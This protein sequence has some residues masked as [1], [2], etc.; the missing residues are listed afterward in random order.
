MR[1]WTWLYFTCQV[2]SLL[3]GATTTLT[4][5]G[6]TVA[7][8]LFHTCVIVSDLSLRCFG[9]GSAD[10]V[11]LLEPTTS[12]ANGFGN[13]GQLGT[14]NN[15]T[16][17]DE[18]GEMGD[19]LMAVDLGENTVQEVAAGQSHTCVLLTGGNVTC[20]GLNLYGQLGLGDTISR[21]L[22]AADMGEGLAFVDLGEGRTA[23][24]ISCGQH[25]TCAILDN[26]DLKCWGNNMH[27]MLGLGDTVHRGD[28]PGTMGDNLQPVDLGTD[29]TAVAVDAGRRHTCAILGNGGVKCWGGDNET[30]HNY[31]QLGQENTFDIGIAAGQMGDNL[32]EINLGTGRTAVALACGWFHTCVILDNAKM[33]CFGRNFYGQL[34]LGD[35]AD[36]GYQPGSMGDAMAS[37][38][39]GGGRYPVAISAGRWHT[40]ALL[41]N[42]DV[43]CFGANTADNLGAGQLGLEDIANRGISLATTGDGLETVELGIG[44]VP[45]WIFAAFDHNCV[46]FIDYSMKCWGLNKSGQLGIGDTSDRGAD[47]NTMGD[48]LPAVEV[49]LR[50][51]S[52]PSPAS[53]DEV[54]LDGGEDGDGLSSVWKVAVSL[55]GAGGGVFVLGSIC[56]CYR[57]RLQKNGI[58]DRKTMAPVEADGDGDGDVESEQRVTFD[59]SRTKPR[60]DMAADVAPYKVADDRQQQHEEQHEL[61]QQQQQHS[62]PGEDQHKFT[63][64]GGDVGV[65]A[66]GTAGMAIAGGLTAGWNVIGLV[67][68]NLPWIGVAYHMLNEIADTVDTKNAMQGNME[69]IKNWA[70]SLQDVLV[71]MAKQMQTQP[72]VNARALEHMSTDVINNLQ[73]LVDTVASYDAKGALTQ[74]LCSRSCQKAVDAAD[75]ALRGALVN[76]SVGQGAE[77]LAMVGRLQGAGLVVDEKLDMIIE[78]L[79]K[80]EEHAARLEL[81]LAEY[82]ESMAEVLGQF[83]KAN[84]IVEGKRKGEQLPPAGKTLRALGEEQLDKLQISKEDVSYPSNVPF[85][86]GAHSEVYQVI[87]EGVIKAAK[88]TNLARLGVGGKDVDRVFGRFV[89]ELYILSQMHS[90]RVVSVYGAIARPTELTLVMEFVERG[91]IRTILDDD[92]A[93]KAMTPVVQHGLVVDTAAGMTYLYN[94]GVEHRDLKSAN[95]LVTHD[96]R[97]KISDFGLSNTND[98]ISNGSSST[99]SSNFRG[100][101]MAY[102]A[103]ELLPGG[104]GASVPAEL[105]DV[106]SFGVVVWDVVCG[107]GE[108]PWAGVS[109]AELPLIL[110]MGKRLDIPTQCGRFY[111]K[112][113]LNCWRQDPHRRPN[114]ERI[115][116]AVKKEANSPPQL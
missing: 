116:Y 98:A 2:G 112:L 25:H 69:K 41:D 27:G 48:R 96:W 103:P 73:I 55:L 10:D 76:L 82:S 57:L 62:P 114:F 84:P 77:V 106:Y 87:H 3:V 91:S 97:V 44:R 28:E 99:T 13:F 85:A 51:A 16:L 105:S 63:L 93:R 11:L 43:K 92:T 1:R 56:L 88:K 38:D 71:Q 34:G 33:H 8:G 23:T 78:H 80:Q 20:F 32:P 102:M 47:V 70:V 58:V 75:T 100:G 115:L 50:L 36:R 64:S 79:R 109:M 24:R 61:E 111:R 46:V 4:T 18:D 59:M 6:S 9:G 81:R 113:M 31:G 72:A 74:Y 26:G 37:V 40:C 39:L 95:C 52:P 5:T 14:G 101:T 29:Q 86:S 60:G 53:F 90:D 7:G 19:D 65:A 45:G 83:A 15:E 67:A 22:S 30:D 66:A 42:G 49:G 17:G 107:D 54:D 108:T 104:A 12:V 35:T 21:G 94:N 110:K 68:Q 89:K